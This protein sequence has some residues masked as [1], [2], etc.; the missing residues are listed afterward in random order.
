MSDRFN[1]FKDALWFPKEETYALV[2]GAGGI[3]SWLTLLLAR[4]GFKPVVYDFDRYEAH[5]MGGQL[6]K[7][8][9]ISQPKVTA[10]QKTVAD[11]CDGEQ[12]MVFNEKYDATK[13]TNPFVFSGFDNMEARSVMFIRW[14]QIYANDPSAIFID[15]RL[16]LEQ[17]QIFCVRGGDQ[18]A[19]A[20]YRDIHLFDDSAVEE[21]AC[22]LKQTS[23]AA[24]MIAAHMVGFFT[25]HY[26]NLVSGSASR[27]IPFKWEYLIP[28]DFLMVE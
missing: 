12:I 4:A 18:E 11:F 24:A 22:T 26:G 7:K 16:T 17:L 23:H 28:L 8:S 6:C 1:R 15:G 19:I 20:K 13:M 21:A 2:G 5:N 27:N 25:N 14:C 3:G 9:D 10:L